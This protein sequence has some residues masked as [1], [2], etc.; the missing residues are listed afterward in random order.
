MTTAK[1]L[2]SPEFIATQRERL[3]ALK[4]DL[5]GAEADS[6]KVENDLQEQRGDEAAEY[7]EMAQDLD[8]REVLQAKH[9]VDRK[10]LDNIDRALKKIELGTYGLSDVSGKA[11]PKARLEASPEAVVTVEEAAARE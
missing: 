4:A 6:L 10:R 8:R 2:L 9:D 1:D 11:I 7:E 5:V 3:E